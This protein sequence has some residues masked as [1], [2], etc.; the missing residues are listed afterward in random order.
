MSI[1]R[2]QILHLAELARVHLTEDEIKKFESELPRI[3][4]FVGQ[5]RSLPAGSADEVDAAHTAL[6]AFRQDTA[7]I[8]P[9]GNAGDLREAFLAYDKEGYLAIPP[10]FDRGD[11]AVG[12]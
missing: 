4:D 9:I 3:L 1:T 12:I 7:N 5:L 8:S 2:E 11:K 6:N 10:V